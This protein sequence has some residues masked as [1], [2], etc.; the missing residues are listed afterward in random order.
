LLT[1]IDVV[2]GEGVG[3]ALALPILGVTP[4]DSLLLREV[5]GLNPPTVDLFIGDYARDGGFYG[6]RRVGQRNVVLT[7]DLNPNPALG[8]TVQGLRELLYKIFIDPQVDADH[9]ELVLHD[10]ADNTRNLFGY[11]ET[12]ETELFGSETVAQISI[13]CPDPYIRDLAS[14]ELLNSSGTWLSLPYTYPGSAETGFEVEIFMSTTSGTLTLEN[15]G[16]LMVFTH[17]FVATDAIYISTN[18][19]FRRAWRA[20]QTALADTRASWPDLTTTEI[21]QKLA[22][23]G[24]TTSLMPNLLLTSP[25]IELHSPENTMKVYG[26]LVSESVAGIKRLEYR[27]TYWGV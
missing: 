14:T 20:S 9:V 19:G 16:K 7:I 10:E 27:P 18:R 1:Q 26:S 12:F 6:G 22:D 8:E 13:I 15:N 11:T 24:Y 2:F 21:W 5:T 25:W 3:E 17:S 23:G 4:N